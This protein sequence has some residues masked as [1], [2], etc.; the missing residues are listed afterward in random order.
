MS[1]T[2][3]GYGDIAATPANT[4]EQ[5]VAVLLMIGGGVMWGQLIG[6]FCGVI[7]MLE[8]DVTEFRATMDK[9]NRFM[10]RQHVPAEMRVR[11]GVTVGRWDTVS[12][13]DGV[14]V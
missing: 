14:V 4:S 8:P 7:S 5:F 11:Y 2:S 13:C 6:T 10:R 12:R 3:I 9:L 1:I